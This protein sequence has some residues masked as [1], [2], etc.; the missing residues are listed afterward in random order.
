MAASVGT[1]AAMCVKHGVQ[2]RQLNP[3]AVQSVLLDS[4]S[5]L[6]QRWYADLGGHAGATID[7]P[8]LDRLLAELSA[9]VVP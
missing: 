1:M 2:P 7:G 3:L 5:T 4:G 9:L 6:I 8:D